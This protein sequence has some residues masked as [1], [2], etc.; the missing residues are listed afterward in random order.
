[1]TARPARMWVYEAEDGWRWQLRAQ[2]GN[3]IADSGQAYVSQRNAVDAARMVA[4]VGIVLYRDG[5]R[6]TLR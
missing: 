4:R 3:I 1:M 6:E 5:N 2:N